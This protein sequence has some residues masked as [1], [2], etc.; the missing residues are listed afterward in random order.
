MIQLIWHIVSTYKH[1]ICAAMG[2]NCLPLDV[3]GWIKLPV[4][5]VEFQWDQQ[6]TVVKNLTVACLL[7]ADVFFIK[8]DDCP[9]G[10]VHLPITMGS[11]CRIPNIDLDD[12]HLSVWMADTTEVPAR[13]I[14]LI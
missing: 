10:Q 12:H 7:G 11:A 4:R 6:F 9:Y 1:G 2:A 13:S 8:V 5:L 14:L 3:I